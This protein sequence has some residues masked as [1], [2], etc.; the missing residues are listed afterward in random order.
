MAKY[1]TKFADQAAYDAGTKQYPNVSLLDDGTVIYMATRPPYQGKALLTYNDGSEYEIACN[2]SSTLTKAEVTGRSGYA[3]D[4]IVKAEIGACTTN[5]EARMFSG[6]TNLKSITI[7]DSV[8]SFNAYF[9]NGC[10]KLESVKIGSGLTRIDTQGFDG[11]QNLSSVTF[12]ESSQL[13]VIGTNAFKNCRSLSSITIPSGV[14]SIG[15]YAFASASSLTNITIPS[16]VTSIGIKAFTSCTSCT[17]ITILAPTPPT[18]GDEYAL[19]FGYF[20]IYV[21]AESVEA[22]KAASGWSA[23]KNR[24]QAIPTT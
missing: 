10:V 1:L 18:L 3:W 19:G 20:P 8:T 16:G 23:Y 12:A 11:C 24:I 17:S 13:T 15:Q 22:Y 2:A 21:H 14:T 5:L 4:S 9:C 7:S 6:N